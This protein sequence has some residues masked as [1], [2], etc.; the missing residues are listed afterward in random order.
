M[1]RSVRLFLALSLLT[2]LAATACSGSSASKST[3]PAEAGATGLSSAPVQT[4]DRAQVDAAVAKLRSRI[5]ATMN[6]K[7]LPG[8]AIGV[9]FDDKGRHNRGLRGPDLGQDAPVDADTVFQ[10]AS[11][12]KSVGGSVMASTGSGSMSVTTRPGA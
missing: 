1:T 6:N 2:F 7:G 3:S 10:L 4:I 11:V 9:V 8:L 5:K 12:S